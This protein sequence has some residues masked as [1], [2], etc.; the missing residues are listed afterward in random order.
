LAAFS[1]EGCSAS[2][3]AAAP[4]GWGRAGTSTGGS[5]DTGRCSLDSHC[6]R[7]GSRFT[8]VKISAI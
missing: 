3:W 5:T 8:S 1:A 7:G 6:G 4:T 2:V